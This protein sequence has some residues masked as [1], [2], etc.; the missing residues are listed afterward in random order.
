MT[1]LSSAA[2]FS[3]ACWRAWSLTS[4]RLVSSTLIIRSPQSSIAK[5]NLG[6][7]RMVRFAVLSDD[8]S[9]VELRSE[10]V[11]ERIRSTVAVLDGL[12]QIVLGQLKPFCDSLAGFGERPL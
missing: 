9:A 10:C 7:V 4:A 8:G 3:R 12:D 11:G 6:G 2:T 5:G 1:D